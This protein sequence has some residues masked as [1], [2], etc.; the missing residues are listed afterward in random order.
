M[1]PSACARFPPGDSAGVAINQYVD[2]EDTKRGLI[3][4]REFVKLHVMVDARGIKIVSCGHHR[5]HSRLAGV[6]EDVR[7]CSGRHGVRDA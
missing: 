2:Q 4:R 1:D 5:A 7:E 6:P 3:S